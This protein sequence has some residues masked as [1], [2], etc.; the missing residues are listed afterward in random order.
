MMVDNRTLE[1]WGQYCA[2]NKGHLN[3]KDIKHLFLVFINMI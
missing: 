2:K 3:A 1:L